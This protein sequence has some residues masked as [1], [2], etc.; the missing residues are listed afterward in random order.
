MKIYLMADSYGTNP[1]EIKGDSIEIFGDDIDALIHEWIE[2]NGKNNIPCGTFTNEEYQAVIAE[3]GQ[4]IADEQFY[5][6]NGGEY[7]ISSPMYIR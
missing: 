3:D 4:D 2:E 1:M 5:P 6:I 7:Y